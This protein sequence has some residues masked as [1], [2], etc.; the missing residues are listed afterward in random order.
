MY[1]LNISSTFLLISAL[2]I[3]PCCKMSAYKVSV[4]TSSLRQFS[5]GNSFWIQPLVEL[6]L[7]L[8]VLLHDIRY[9]LVSYFSVS[10]HSSTMISLWYCH[11]IAK[12][13]SVMSCHDIS[14]V[15]MP[16]YWH[17]RCHAMISAMWCHAMI[18][19]VCSS[20]AI[21]LSSCHDVVMHHDVMP[22]YYCNV[23]L[24]FHISLSNLYSWLL[25]VVPSIEI[26]RA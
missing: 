26:N 18:S 21:S 2:A 9:L 24:I 17:I 4:D 11:D 1:F 15:V 8:F 19:Y 13:S 20:S 5:L 6:S 10:Y 7:A 25:I 3:S 12:I 14:V 23:F 22:W 16:W